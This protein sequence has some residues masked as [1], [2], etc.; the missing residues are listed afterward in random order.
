MAVSR[1]SGD[2]IHPWLP[3][4]GLRPFLVSRDVIV[5]RPLRA[6]TV[7]QYQPS[8]WHYRPNVDLDKQNRCSGKRMCSFCSVRLGCLYISTLDHTKSV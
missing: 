5:E 3:N 8:D 7:I 2:E 4:G 1:R 6:K